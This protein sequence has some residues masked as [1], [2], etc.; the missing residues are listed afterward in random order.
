MLKTYTDLPI[1]DLTKHL[2]HVKKADFEVELV[3]G[4]YQFIATFSKSLQDKLTDLFDFL[5]WRYLPTALKIVEMGND[6][7]EHMKRLP[8]AEQNWASAESC[9]RKL[10]CLDAISGDIL[11]SVFSFK[12][13]SQ[14]EPAD[15]VRR[16]NTL[17][18]AAGVVDSAGEPNM[19]HRYLIE[20][21]FR[22]VPSTGQ[23]VILTH[24]KD[25]SAVRDYQELLN[26][27][28][29]SKNILIGSHK[30]AGRWAAT[31]WAPDLAPKDSGSS[32]SSSSYSNGG[33]KRRRSLSP[34]N[35]N[36]GS[37]SFK[38]QNSSNS[39]A[40]P[41]AAKPTS[42]FLPPNQKWCDHPRCVTLPEHAK[43]YASSCRHRPELQK[44]TSSSNSSRSS[45]SSYHSNNS[46][47]NW[48]YNSN[49]KVDSAKQFN[50]AS[51]GNSSALAPQ[52]RNK[53]HIE[54]QK[55][56][57]LADSDSDDDLVTMT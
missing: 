16:F 19:P 25:L 49:S 30:W 23:Q 54:S 42:R 34:H 10:F 53:G 12:S 31:K 24:F 56:N 15:F 18:R 17:I 51:S 39:H 55:D 5:A 20:V 21:L 45:D 40:S 43:H 9:L 1:L 41:S 11:E 6:F 38:P 29:E 33:T 26:L 57:L 13:I 37:N 36:R 35:R 44:S 52:I 7:H 14:E 3:K 46:S 27:I 47:N 4:I 32:V 28:R 48:R 2:R 8:R 50:P 22:A